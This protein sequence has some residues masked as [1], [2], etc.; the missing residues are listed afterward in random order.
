MVPA[1]CG[2]SD[3]GGD[4]G[5]SVFTAAGC[6]DCHT[7]SAAGT[8]GTVGPNLDQ[9]RPSEQRVVEQVA[10]GGGAMPSFADRLSEAEISNVAA[11][12][13]D[14]TGG[15]SESGSVAA[16]FVPDSTTLGDCT[17]GFRCYEQ[18]FANVSYRRGPD[19][20]L[21]LLE[22]RAATPGPIESNCHRI[23]HAIGAGAL[24][25]FQGDPGKA[26]ARGSVFCASGYY[27]GIL[28]R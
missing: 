25:H 17:S 5:R 28:E 23:T 2:G 7:L 14:A 19:R 1:A 15:N 20:A 13:A 11:F 4:P 12:V 26:L 24:A 6:G 10:Q 3:E 27:H 22:Q 16:Q 9:T 8:T 18:A 21:A